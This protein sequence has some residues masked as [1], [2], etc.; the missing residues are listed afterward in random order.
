MKRERRTYQQTYFWAF[1][2]CI[3]ITIVLD[4]FNISVKESTEYATN[5]VKKTIENINQVLLWFFPTALLVK[6]TVD[7][8]MD[9]YFK[10]KVDIE[11]IRAKLELEE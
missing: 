10:S 1:I 7:E 8:W 2:G 5:I 6:K 9:R 4:Y 3:I 11:K